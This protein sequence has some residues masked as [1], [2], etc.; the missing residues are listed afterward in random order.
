DVF[1]IAGLDVVARG[2]DRRDGD[3]GRRD[4]QPWSGGEQEEPGERE[5]GADG[6]DGGAGEGRARRADRSHRQ[7][8]RGGEIPRGQRVG[9]RER[10][11]RRGSGGARPPVPS[12]DHADAEHR[13]P[14][15]AREDRARGEPT[16]QVAGA[17]G[18]AADGGRGQHGEREGGHPGDGV[19][20]PGGGG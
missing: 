12:G 2:R 8:H 4:R 17:G 9:R 18:R 19:G 16:D 3:T 5:R 14:E 11:G 10:V 7:G 1:Q 6:L 13:A 20:G 15:D